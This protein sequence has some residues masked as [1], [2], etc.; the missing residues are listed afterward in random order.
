MGDGPPV[1]VVLASGKHAR[2]RVQI[3]DEKR[4]GDPK[5]MNCDDRTICWKILL[6]LYGAIRFRK[7]SSASNS[8]VRTDLSLPRTK[9]SCLQDR[10]THRIRNPRVRLERTTPAMVHGPLHHQR[11]CLKIGLSL[12]TS[13]YPTY[14]QIGATHARQA[15]NVIVCHRS[16]SHDVLYLRSSPVVRRCFMLCSGRLVRS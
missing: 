1:R 15:L 8:C 11:I 14:P 9:S 5:S 7:P 12:Q 16:F 3:R 6:D 13:R 2:I 10:M 4:P